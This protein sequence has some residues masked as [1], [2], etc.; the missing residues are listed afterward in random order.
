[1]IV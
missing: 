1:V